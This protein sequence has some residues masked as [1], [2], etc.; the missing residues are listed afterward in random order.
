MKAV[1]PALAR[2][3]VEP[4]LPAGLEV[5]WFT[6]AEEAEAMVADADIGWVDIN[7]PPEW[8][9]AVAAGEK[10]Q[11]LST[12]YAG[13]DRLDTEQLRARGT[14]VTNGSGVNAH[15]VA[16]YAVMG[17]LVA[18]KR[19]DQVVRIADRHEWPFDAPG[20]LELFETSALV[21]GYGTIGRLI[22]ERLAGFGVT[23]TGVTRTGAPGTILPDAWR[24]RLAA[25]DWVFLSAP[26]T[27]ESR[28]MIGEAELRAMKPSAWLINVGRGELVDQDALIEAVTKRRIAG[29][30]LDT[31]TPEPLPPEH[32]LW[33][34]PNILHSM[35]LSG[36]SQTRMFVRAAELFVRNLHAFIAGDP[37]ENEVDLEAGY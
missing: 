25:F 35:H 13:L 32:P 23:V 6:S 34:T 28:A 33:S 9:R 14:R 37:L 19:Y 29:A 36:R 18:A 27:G 30:F 2:P 3:L 20:K 7:R 16:E 12:I 22:G 4:H 10:L 15:T 17:A 11:W 31:V 24:T 5:R 8:A 26:A 1:L 21:I